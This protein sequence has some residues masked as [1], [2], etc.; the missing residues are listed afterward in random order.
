MLLGYPIGEIVCSRSGS[1]GA[2][3]VVGILAGLFGIGGGAIIVPVLYE[4]FRVLD[5]PE[6]VR[7]Q[8]CIGTSLAIIV[9][10]TIR[11]YIAHKKKGA[12]IPHVV[13]LWA[14]P[15]IA[16]VAIGSVDRHV[17]AGRGVQD[18]LRDLRQLHRVTHAVRRRPLESRQRIAGPRAARRSTASSPACFRRWSAS[19]AARCRTRCSRSTAS[20][21][22]ARSRPPPASACRSPLPA[23]SATCWPAGRTWRNCRRCRSASCR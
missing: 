5:V 19:A 2:G 1:L 21:C 17:R 13:R 18:R 4:V 8:M 14:V 20:R 6:D 3:I 12:V 10:T 23:P 15:A 9:P 7:M 11:S 16:G 22:S